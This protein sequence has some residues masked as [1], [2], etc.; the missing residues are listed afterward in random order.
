MEAI[1]ESKDVKKVGK[2]LALLIDRE[3]AYDIIDQIGNAK[4]IEDFIDGLW[5]AMRLAKKIESELE[6]MK[7]KSISED[8]IPTYDDINNVISLAEKDNKNL[9][10]LSRYLG[11]LAFCK[12][13]E[14]KKLERKE[15]NESGGGSRVY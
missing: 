13:F 14:I 10:F 1:L 12:W 5:K 11:S 6:D 15:K 9:R 2:Y 3:N 4:N 7:H 8:F